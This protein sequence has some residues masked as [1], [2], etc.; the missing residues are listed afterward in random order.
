[1][2]PSMQRWPALLITSAAAFT[3]ESTMSEF[4]FGNVSLG[5]DALGVLSIL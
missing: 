3:K 1:V 5:P 4:R 2:T